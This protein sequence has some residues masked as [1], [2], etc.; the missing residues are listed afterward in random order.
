MPAEFRLLAVALLLAAP[1]SA[2]EPLSAIDWLSKSVATPAAVV[3][4]EAPTAAPGGALPAAVTTS[5]LGGPNPDAAG[6]LATAVT[7]LPHDLWGLGSTTE[8]GRAIAVERSGALPALRG[9]LLTLLLAEA[10]APADS[11]GRGTLLLARIDK[12]LEIGALDQAEALIAASGSGGPDLFRRAFDIAMLTGTEDR[13]CE[14]MQKTPDLAPTFPARIFCLAR[15][16]D[17]NAAALSLR[18]GQALGQITAEEDALLS[19]FLDPDLYEGEPQLDPP[20][21]LTPLTWRMLEAIGEAPPTNVL[22]LAFS[23]ADLREASGWKARI[24]A[25]ERLSRAGVV[26]P[27]LLLGLYTERKPSASGGV[28]D[29]AEAFQRIETALT[30]RDPM[31]AAATL[32]PAWQRMAEAELE[33]PFAT[34]FAGELARLPLPPEVQA[35]SFRIALLGPDYEVAA[36]AHQPAD[37]TEAFLIGLARG[38]LSGLV[39]PDSLARAIAPAFAE[40]PLAADLQALLDE[41]RLGEAILA[42]ID[43]IDRGVTGDLRGV[44]EGLALLRHVGLEDI[45]RRTALELMLLE[46]RG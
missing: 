1:V 10:E 11:A 30:A 9:L 3:A 12:L 37:A 35:L 27:N 29:R 7:G 21:P 41:K 16:G 23:H 4:P 39:P 18:T 33:V 46:R 22:P 28:W 32:A 24:E 8:V 19:R 38:D 17:W 31:A 20:E 14:A 40:A 25:A 15:S 36:T 34:L 45:A 42:A 5:V 44:T 2:E 13:S 26:E 6:L 43:R